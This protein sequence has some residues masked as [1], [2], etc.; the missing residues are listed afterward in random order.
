[1]SNIAGYVYW[2]MIFVIVDHFAKIGEYL[3]TFLFEFTFLDLN[4][5]VTRFSNVVSHTV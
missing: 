5:S 4:Y 3:R 1:M 2:V